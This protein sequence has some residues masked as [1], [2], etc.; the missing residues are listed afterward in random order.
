[1]LTGRTFKLRADLFGVKTDPN[2]KRVAIT[3]PTGETFR[4]FTRSVKRIPNRSWGA[5]HFRQLPPAKA[6]ENLPAFSQS[7]YL[8]RAAV[9]TR[10]PSMTELSAY[11]L[12]P[13]RNKRQSAT[14]H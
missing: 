3:I 9:V 4:V 14:N 8:G 5:K 13:I 10:M 11:V 12:E 6:C 7:V 2:G 1:M